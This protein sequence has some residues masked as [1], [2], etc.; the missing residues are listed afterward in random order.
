MLD[1]ITDS[2]VA[3]Y[4]CPACEAQDEVTFSGWTFYTEAG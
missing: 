2:P 3:T 4:T 1:E